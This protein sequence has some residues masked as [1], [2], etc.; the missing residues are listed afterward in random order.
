MTGSRKKTTQ[1]SKF[2]GKKDNTNQQ[3]L[4]EQIVELAKEMAFMQEELQRK[5]P[6]LCTPK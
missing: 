5:Q 3:A 4:V 2:K 6:T 1:L